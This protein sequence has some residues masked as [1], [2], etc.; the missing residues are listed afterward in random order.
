MPD[1]A[2]FKVFKEFSGGLNRENTDILK[3]QLGIVARASLNA[4]NLVYRLRF[5]CLHRVNKTFSS[6]KIKMIFPLY[7]LPTGTNSGMRL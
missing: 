4:K 2:G 6:S 5:C 7:Q 1:P 3:C